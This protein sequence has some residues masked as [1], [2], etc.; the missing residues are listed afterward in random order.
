MAAKGRKKNNHED[1]FWLS[2]VEELPRA[3]VAM[4]TKSTK[5]MRFYRRWIVASVVIAPISGLA[6]VTMLPGYLEPDP[7]PVVAVSQIDAPTKAAAITS[8]EAWL[9]QDPSPLPGGRILSWDG[10]D[11]QAEP[12][13][14]V[15]DATQR[16]VEEQGL[17]LHDL[18]LIAGNG[19][20]F[21]TTV[22]VAYSEVRG[23]QVLGSPTL[24]PR[25]PSDTTAWPNLETWP[26]LVSA[27]ASDNMGQAANAWAKAFASGD[28]DA[29][30]LAVGDT[31]GNHAYVPLSQAKPSDITVD[32]AAARPDPKTGEASKSPSVV[33]ARVSF[34][35]TWPGQDTKGASSTPPRLTYDVLF[36]RADTASPVVVAWGGTGSGPQLEKYQNAIVDREITADS[37]TGPVTV[38]PHEEA[39]SESD[40]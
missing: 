5:R 39:N 24:I 22:Q 7:E 15:D 8:V 3:D 18:T 13:I 17:Q 37:I 36:D 30:R 25:A 27:T 38:D 14:Y 21:S 35:V 32:Q 12:R 28:P 10:M 20:L 4:A 29:L 34:N 19:T 9:G 33:V 16:T 1:D 2:G 23:S 31:A 40:E 11:V 6:I 26:G